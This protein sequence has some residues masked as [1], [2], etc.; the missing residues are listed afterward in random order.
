[1]LETPMSNPHSLTMRLDRYDFPENP[2][3]NLSNLVKNRLLYISAANGFGHPIKYAV[4]ESGK[5]FAREHIDRSEIIGHVKNMSD[6][7][8]MMKLVQVIFS[9]MQNT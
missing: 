1:M 3:K 9:K 4:T 2:E 7:D 8:F 5:Q 6:P